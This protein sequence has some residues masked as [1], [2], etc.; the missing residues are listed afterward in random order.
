[1]SDETRVGL[2]DNY[3]MR[4]QYAVTDNGLVITKLV[5]ELR[6]GGEVG[7]GITSSVLQRIG[8]QRLRRAVQVAYRE[9][10]EKVGSDYV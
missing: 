8:L 7:K 4:G 1:V 10:V 9:K 2:D 3:E 5:V 6:A